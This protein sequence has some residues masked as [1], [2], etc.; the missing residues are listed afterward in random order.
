M[1]A[2]VRVL[3]AAHN[4]PTCVIKVRSNQSCISP[5]MAARTTQMVP[6][7][8]LTA[9]L[10]P[11]MVGTEESG[12]WRSVPEQWTAWNETHGAFG[13]PRGTR[14]LHARGSLVNAELGI[15]GMWLPVTRTHVQQDALHVGLWFHYTRGCSDTA[16]HVGRTLLVRNKCESAGRIEQRATG[17]QSWKEAMHAVAQRLLEAARRRSF[18]ASFIFDAPSFTDLTTSDVANALHRCAH[19]R[20]LARDR[21]MSN[22]SHSVV[23][24]LIGSNALDYVS[25]AILAEISMEGSSAVLDTVQ[26]SNRCADGEDGCDGNVEVWDVRSLQEVNLTLAR[27]EAERNDAVLELV[28]QH[29]RAGADEKSVDA[30]LTKHQNRFEALRQLK[31][32][33]VKKALTSSKRPEHY[34]YLN[35]S[36]CSLTSSWFHCFACAGAE[37]ES[38]CGFKCSR[39][40]GAKSFHFGLKGG[41]EYAGYDERISLWLASFHRNA[42]DVTAVMGYVNL[43]AARLTGAVPLRAQKSSK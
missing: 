4:E 18:R 40:K 21:Q 14:F 17:S 42:L 35:G 3:K 2:P 23:Q 26:F 10:A 11:F 28:A 13:L 5:A 41:H 8:P 37:S 39:P 33:R 30:M 20:P 24:Y 16:W 34:R 43:Q 9:A 12:G 36:A 27:E 32:H 1:H 7:A 31:M 22:A 25:G 15:D 19:G 29:R 6:P 38:S